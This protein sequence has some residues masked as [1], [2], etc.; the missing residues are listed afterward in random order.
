MSAS[1]SRRFLFKGVS[2]AVLVFLF[3]LS[4]H[5]A[6]VATARTHTNFTNT[7]ALKFLLLLLQ[8]PVSIQALNR[9]MQSVSSH[10]QVTPYI[11]TGRLMLTD[12][13]KGKKT[14]E[15]TERRL[16]LHINLGQ[17]DIRPSLYW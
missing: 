13:L 17:S 6:D 5:L 15:E 9:H 4:K 14:P 11:L 10:E 8:L 7:L 1:L 2:L 12:K 16:A 3:P